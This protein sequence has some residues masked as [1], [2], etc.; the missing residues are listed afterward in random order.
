MSQVLVRQQQEPLLPLQ[1]K[2]ASN[3]QREIYQ[4]VADHAKT[5][6]IPIP[7]VLIAGVDGTPKELLRSRG[8]LH[9][10]NY[11]GM[12]LVKTHELYINPT[13]IKKTQKR[14]KEHP[15]ITTI[16]MTDAI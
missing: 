7:T 16:G 9:Y 2:L 11:L 3:R 13:A 10:R 8:E 12:A 6:G 4:Q 15:A 5:L 14:L 1:T